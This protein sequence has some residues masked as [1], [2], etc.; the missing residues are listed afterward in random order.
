MF[1]A[2][3]AFFRSR[4]TITTAAPPFVKDQSVS[5]PTPDVAPVRTH[6]FPCISTSLC[7]WTAFLFLRN[8]SSS[9]SCIYN[10]NVVLAT[11]IPDIK[12]KKFRKNWARLIQKVYHFDPLLCSKCNSSMKIISFIEDEATIK[13]ILKHLD[14]WMPMNHDPPSRKD[15]SMHIQP[16][17]SFEWWENKI[18][19]MP[20]E[21]EYSQLTPYED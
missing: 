9:G 18:S 8:I 10:D 17:R 13:K 11:S 4:Q 3:S 12:R 21:D 2:A 16:H 1:L 14:L 19:N 15:L 7:F 20:Y 5:N 6:S